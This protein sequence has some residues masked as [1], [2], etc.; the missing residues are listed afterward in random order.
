MMPVHVCPWISAVAV[1][2]E[3]SMR[4]SYYTLN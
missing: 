2:I 4:F 1:G 3:K